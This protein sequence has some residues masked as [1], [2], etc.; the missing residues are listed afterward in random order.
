MSDETIT[1]AITDPM[2]TVRAKS[3]LENRAKLRSPIHRVAMR[4]TTYS[5]AA[6]SGT[7]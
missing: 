5:T 2:A 6:E 7:V 3:K 4:R 1:E